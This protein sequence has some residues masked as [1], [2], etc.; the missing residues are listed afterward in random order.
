M[1]LFTVVSTE[2]RKSDDQRLVA[3]AKRGDEQ[4]K[5][6]AESKRAVAA[7][8]YTKRADEEL[9]FLPGTVETRAAMLKAIDAIPDEAQRKEALEALKAQN[10]AMEL[11]FKQQGVISRVTPEASDAEGQLDTLAKAEAESSKT[12]YETAYAKVC[13]TK[14]GQRL[15]AESVGL[16]E[17]T[18]H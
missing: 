14:E 13:K 11:A 9:K 5:E 3:M 12:T 15:Y 4:A 18:T 6:L 1:R 8:G 16:V 10:A 2:Y 17:V 7:A